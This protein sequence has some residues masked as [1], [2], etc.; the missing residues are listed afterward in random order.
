[1]LDVQLDWSEIR[2]DDI[3]SWTMLSVSRGIRKPTQD[4]SLAVACEGYPNSNGPP[5]GNMS[6]SGQ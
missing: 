6:R 1:V 2:F 5:S 3:P 4:N